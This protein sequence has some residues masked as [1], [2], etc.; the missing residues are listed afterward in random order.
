MFKEG[1]GGGTY[2]VVVIIFA[3]HARGPRFDP[4]YVQ[5]VLLVQ[6]VE[7][8]SKAICGRKEEGDVSDVC[9]RCPVEVLVCIKCKM[10][11]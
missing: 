2:D 9:V 11:R 5:R 3:S 4:E 1:C 7:V 10:H 8:R 6:M